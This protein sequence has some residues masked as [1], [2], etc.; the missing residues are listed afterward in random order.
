MANRAQKRKYLIFQESCR[1][2]VDPT[3][4]LEVSGPGTQIEVAIFTFN[5]F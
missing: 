2:Y 3:W 4:A 5:Q 1:T